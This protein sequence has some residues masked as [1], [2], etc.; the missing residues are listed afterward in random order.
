MTDLL[1][2][3]QPPNSHRSVANVLLAEDQY[4]NDRCASNWAAVSV[5]VE[6]KDKLKVLNRLAAIFCDDVN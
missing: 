2:E 3:E 6:T 1:S 4:R 5:V